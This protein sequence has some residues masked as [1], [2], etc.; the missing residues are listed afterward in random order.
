MIRCC[1]LER[2]FIQRAQQERLGGGLVPDVYTIVFLVVMGFIASFID[3]VVGGGGL[4]S[5]PALMW[6]GLPPLTVLG[7]N[8]AA[9]VMGAVTSFVSFMRSGRMDVSLI[10]KLFP[11]SFI[12]SAI[13][14]FT[15]RMI[16][17][18]FLRPLVIVM[19][20]AVAV[21]SVMKKDWG[22]KSSYRGMTKR[23]MIFSFL[24]AFVF[25]FYDG[26]F[27]PG[28]G[29]FILFAFLLIGFDFIGAA[30]NARALNFASNL[31]AFILFTSLGIANYWYA[32]PMG[33]A[34]VAGAIVGTKIAITKGAKYVRPL[35]IAVTTILIGKQIFDMIR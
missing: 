18:N 19:L 16:P 13:G 28:T 20:I 8:K 1:S 11:L 24:V 34:M 5:I 27:G 32:V 23:N 29:S 12:G 31:A 4:I 26:F 10:K 30:A 15:V 3:S 17:P 14:V 7:T 22:D 21:Y 6:T 35:F 25:G 33:L 9:A 2:F